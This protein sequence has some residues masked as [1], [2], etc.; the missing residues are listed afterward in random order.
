MTTHTVPCPNC[1][2][3]GRVPM[4]YCEVCEEPSGN[5]VYCSDTCYFK[6]EFRQGDL[7]DS[8]QEGEPE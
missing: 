1:E 2:G 8:R 7:A 4:K 5:G 6:N 3:V